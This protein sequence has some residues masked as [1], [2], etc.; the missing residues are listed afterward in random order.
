MTNK[1]ITSIEIHMYSS[2]YCSPEGIIA[3]KVMVYRSGKIKHKLFNG[4]S[5]VAVQE[6]EYDVS[7]T[8]LEDFFEYLVSKIKV[9]DWK[10]DYSVEVCDGWCC[11]F[12]VRYSNH[13]V[14]NIK[15]TVEA[16]PNAK[17][18]EKRI[19]KLVK[20]EVEPWIF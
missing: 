1:R 11:D 5:E 9:E 20:F 17:Q 16:P 10:L 15:G 19:K 8:D 2:G 3:E 14:I 13:Q 6:F 4:L 7:K 12:K 18:L